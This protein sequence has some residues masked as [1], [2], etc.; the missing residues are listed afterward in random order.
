MPDTPD[1]LMAGDSTPF[2]WISEHEL[3]MDAVDLTA[4]FSA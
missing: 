2:A 4:K 3:V 1:A